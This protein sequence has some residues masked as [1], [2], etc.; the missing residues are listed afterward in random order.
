MRQRVRLA[1]SV[2][3]AYQADLLKELDEREAMSSDIMELR[4]TADLALCAT[5]ETASAI[6]RSMA[7]LVAAE[8][9]MWLTMSD[10]REKDRV[11]LLDTPLAPSGLFGGP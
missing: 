6:G 9:H 11:F 10:I 8:M 2:L 5:K 4:R 3:Q 7:A 1:M